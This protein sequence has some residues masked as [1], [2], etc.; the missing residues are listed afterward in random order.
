MNEY[1]LTDTITETVAGAQYQ[2]V[3]HLF[4]ITVKTRNSIL[5]CSWMMLIGNEEWHQDCKNAK[6]ISKSSI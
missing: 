3:V 1:D 2:Y 6:A 5:S 4:N